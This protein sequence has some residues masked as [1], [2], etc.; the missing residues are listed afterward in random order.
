M[1]QQSSPRFDH[2][3]RRLQCGEFLDMD[4]YSRFPF[5]ISF[6]L[7]YLQFKITGCNDHSP[8]ASS[9]NAAWRPDGC[10]AIWRTILWYPCFRVNTIKSGSISDSI[11]DS[12]HCQ[13]SGRGFFGATACFIFQV[14]T[15]IILWPFVSAIL[16][17]VWKRFSW[18]L[19][20]KWYFRH[21]L[22]IG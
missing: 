5:L 20:K 22:L 21:G 18:I 12:I 17:L 16:S 11:S 10:P 2:Q 3:S 13:S 8:S 14:A 4:V 6:E 1:Y 19:G 9:T 7:R 15:R